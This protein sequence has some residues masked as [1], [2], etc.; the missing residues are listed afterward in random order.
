ARFLLGFLTETPDG[1]LVT[2]PSVSPENTYVLPNGE[3]G[4][5]CI[6]ASMDSQIAGELFRACVEASR[7]LGI[8]EAFRERL[9]QALARLPQPAIGRHGQLREW[10]EDYEEAEPGHRHISHLF[11]LH[12]GTR[13]TPRKTP[14]LAQAARTT[15]VR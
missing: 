1:K 8:D 11:A 6:A 14:D 15:L 2:N 10:L 3:S 5:L 12:P 9:R 4:T 7:L 13:I